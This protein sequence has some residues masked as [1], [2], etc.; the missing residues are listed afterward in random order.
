MTQS[1]YGI[2][3]EL[4]TNM[5]LSLLF[6]KSSS[7][8]EHDLVTMEKRMLTSYPISRLLPLELNEMNLQIS[9]A[10]KL[11]AKKSLSQLT[12]HLKLNEADCLR[13]LFTI[14]TTLVDSKVH[15]LNEE[16]YLLEE[17]FI[18]IGTDYLDV[19]LIYLP[20]YE[21]VGKP[22]LPI[23]LLNLLTFL[24]KKQGMP[25]SQNVRE[26]KAMLNA[27]DFQL[28]A[29][30]EKLLQA[31]TEIETSIPTSD[32]IDQPEH[33]SQTPRL[34]SNM[35]IKTSGPVQEIESWMPLTAKEKL[36]NWRLKGSHNPLLIMASIISLGIVWIL[37]SYYSSIG[38]LN[39]CLGLSLLILNISL[40]LNRSLG[41]MDTGELSYT[42]S[43]GGPL[44]QQPYSVV[45]ESDYYEQ[46]S[47]QTTLLVPASV[48]Y[49]DAT[50][51]LS[52][53][54]KAFL[55]F[56]QGE[57]TQL[58]EISSKSFIIG[59][60]Q[61]VAQFSA[62][63]LGLSRSHIMITCVGNDCEIKDL[64]SKNGSFLNEEIMVPHQNY[65]LNE[66]DCIKVVE[67]QFIY[68]KL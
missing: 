65:K 54:L 28:I 52:P 49:D 13:I 9:L 33:F 60:N 44:I 11:G 48:V 62:D 5:G 23:E 43:F 68:K 8:M 22:C 25:Q 46:L 41:M 2:Q 31:I 50:V 58:I 19:H 27:T 14:V 12:H 53:R 39:L 36:Q 63:W 59:R 6:T 42:N 47:N 1:I 45:P 20:I 34:Q 15:L 37:Y 64:G 67:K 51:I 61:E 21:F 32:Y 17:S 55:E 18:F 30:K 66:G 40:W 56:K 7:W 16:R 3:Y 29:L 35:D 57:E 24:L 26:I 4:V 38:M 10:Y